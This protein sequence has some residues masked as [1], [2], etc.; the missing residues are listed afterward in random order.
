MTERRLTTDSID[1][2]DAYWA[3]SFGC[4]SEA[5]RPPRALVLP[6][7]PGE[8][9]NGLYAMTFGASP[10]VSVPQ[11]VFGAVRSSLASWT[12][13]TIRDPAGATD[14]VGPL[15]GSAIGPA[16]VGYADEATLRSP[17]LDVRARLLS[18]E[19]AAAVFDAGDYAASRALGRAL[20]ELGSAGVVYR[21]VRHAKGQ[22]VGLFKARGAKACLH[23]AV[24]LY[25]WDGQRFCDIFEKVD[26]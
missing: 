7:G 10:I 14:A 5:L 17:P 20:H 13:E 22:C 24:L 23:A 19:D 18:R 1:A 3:T 6:H 9:F 15:A 25:A 16:W 26:A 4:P 8:R 2:I 12:A 21:S 11:G